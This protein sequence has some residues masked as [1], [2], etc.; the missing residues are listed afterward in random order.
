MFFHS[1]PF[2]YNIY[3]CQFSWFIDFNILILNWASFGW[4]KTVSDKS[5]RENFYWRIIRAS[6]F[7]RWNG[8]QT[9]EFFHFIE[10]PTLCSLKPLCRLQ[11]TKIAL[12]IINHTIQDLQRVRKHDTKQKLVLTSCA[13]SFSESWVKS[14]FVH[15]IQM[16]NCC[17]TF[18]FSSKYDG[19][20]KKLCHNK[21]LKK[22]KTSFWIWIHITCGR[23]QF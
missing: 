12:H 23:F 10:R 16:I 6:R 22:L 17:T 4:Y 2:A 15:D 3:S 8:R 5:K 14:L 7:M 20:F 9:Q 19:S 1:T 11:K 13:S 21:S 18:H